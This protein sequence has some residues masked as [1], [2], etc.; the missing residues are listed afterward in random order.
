MFVT[1]Y[2]EPNAQMLQFSF[3]TLQ[4]QTNLM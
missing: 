1:S 2:T 3:V 4:T